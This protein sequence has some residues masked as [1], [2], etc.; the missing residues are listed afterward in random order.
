VSRHGVQHEALL[1]LLEKLEGHGRI[2]D[3]VGSR[4]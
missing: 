2:G 4:I 1:H 3:S